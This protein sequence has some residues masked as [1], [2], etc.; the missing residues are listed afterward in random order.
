M[1]KDKADLSPERQSE[2]RDLANMPD[3]YINTDDIPETTEWADARRGLFFWPVNMRPKRER[4]LTC[5][6][7]IT[8]GIRTAITLALVMATVNVK[9]A[10]AQ[11]TAVSG[12][13]GN[14]TGQIETARSTTGLTEQR[15][16]FYL[17]GGVNL[18][19]S[20][21]TRFGD[22]DCLSVS[23]AALYGCGKGI[24][25][26]PLGSTGDFGTMT[27]GEIGFG[28]AATPLL[29]FEALLQ[30]RPGF[31]YQG[32]ANFV[33]TTGDQE[34]TAELSSVSGMLAAYLD[35][36]GFGPF[37]P[38]LGSGGGL[39]IVDIEDT[40]MT[41]P[42]TNTIVPSGR[43]VDFA[44]M[45]TAGFA[46]TLW[47]DLALDVGWRYTDWG[48]VATGVD[49]GRV[50]W[51]DG[52]RDPLELELAETRAKLSGHGLLLSLRYAL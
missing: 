28:Y 9:Q 25:G 2:I 34:V 4:N 47:A 6:R 48:F 27:G 37:R 49:T 31:T 46:T 10:G 36:P 8:M 26:S 43:C 33:Q 1:S 22:D 21:N 41:F 52:R 20:S 29:R 11:A 35:L 38:F 12:S 40:H 24:G 51:R 45:M 23:P 14:P 7:W 30:Y 42:N 19:L 17:R 44:V 18:D 32:N 39:N 16:G 3:S 13:G 5:D 15:N 50:I